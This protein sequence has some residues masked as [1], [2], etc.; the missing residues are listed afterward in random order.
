MLC[1]SF[2]L[3][4]YVDTN[5]QTVLCASNSLMP[6]IASPSYTSHLLVFCALTLSSTEQVYEARQHLDAIL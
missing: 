5:T 4:T 1:V 6:A 3:G 2:L